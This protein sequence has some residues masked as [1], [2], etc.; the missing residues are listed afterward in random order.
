MT[1]FTNK[2]A[3]SLLQDGLGL[4]PSHCICTFWKTY[5]YIIQKAV[6]VVTLHTFSTVFSVEV[7]RL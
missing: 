1:S 5:Y 7:E 6:Y 2:T 3:T 4:S